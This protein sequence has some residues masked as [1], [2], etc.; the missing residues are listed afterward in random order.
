MGRRVAIAESS[1]SQNLQ[2]SRLVK[3]CNESNSLINLQFTFSELRSGV[4]RASLC[5]YRKSEIDQLLYN[6]LES[7]LKYRGK[8][9][10]DWK[11]KEYSA[12]IAGGIGD[13]NGEE[14]KCTGCNVS[15]MILVDKTS[16]CRGP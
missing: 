2:I 7:C 4:V 6:T 5:S 8:S 13:E 9:E 3:P 10:T 15:K 11:N 14:C 12:N 1:I 16:T